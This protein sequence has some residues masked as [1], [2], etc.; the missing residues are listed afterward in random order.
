M[1]CSNDEEWY[2]LRSA[3][4]QLMMRPREVAPFLPAVDSVAVDFVTHLK[5][6]RNHSNEVPDFATE[7]SRWSLECRLKIELCYR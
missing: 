5:R 6:L 4:Q 1:P 3:V 7:L 2:R